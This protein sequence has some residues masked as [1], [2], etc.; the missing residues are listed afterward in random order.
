MSRCPDPIE[1][2]RISLDHLV[3][4]ASIPGW[5]AYAW[6]RAQALEEQ[7]IF[8]G[9]ANALKVRMRELNAGPA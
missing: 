1:E 3:R 5:K 7:A 9:I 4:M 8:K 6:H 2:Y